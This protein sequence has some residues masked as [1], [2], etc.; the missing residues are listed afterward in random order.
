MAWPIDFQVD[1]SSIIS[2]R[3][4]L[5]KIDHRIRETLLDLVGR[6][7]TC[8]ALVNELTKMIA[9][10]GEPLK[11]LCVGNREVAISQAL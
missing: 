11:V 5:D 9:A 7:I 1:S 3:E 2:H 10:P 4:R 6:S 8:E